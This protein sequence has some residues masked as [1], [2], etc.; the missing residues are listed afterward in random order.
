MLSLTTLGKADP[1]LPNFYH[2]LSLFWF[3]SWC[4]ICWNDFPY[5]VYLLIFG[6]HGVR[7]LVWI[8]IFYALYLI[9]FLTHNWYSKNIDWMEEQLKLLVPSLSKTREAIAL[10]IV[11]LIFLWPAYDTLY[12]SFVSE[13]NLQCLCW[14]T[15]LRSV[16][17]LK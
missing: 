12:N 4:S 16:I 10:R 1:Y 15:M 2:F 5:L 6:L 8:I 7:Y 13:V 9:L 3:I 14:L 17:F 11:S